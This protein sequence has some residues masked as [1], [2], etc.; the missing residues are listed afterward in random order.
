LFSRI[1]PLWERHATNRFLTGLD[2]L[3][4]NAK[5]IPRLSAL[6]HH[7]HPLTGFRARAVSGYIPSYFFF[8]RLRRREFPTTITIRDASQIDYL[9]EPDIFHDVAGHVPMHT[10]PAF[11][12][13]L[14]KFGDCAHSAMK[15]ASGASDRMDVLANILKGM[16]RF[17][18]FTVEFGLMNDGRGLKAYG[19][20]LMSSFGELEHSVISPEVERR[21]MNMEQVIHQPF[22]I[23]H[24]QPLLYVIES[25]EQLFEMV[26]QLDHW[27]QEGRL[28]HVAAGEPELAP[29]DLRSFVERLDLAA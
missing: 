25:F 18:W 12:N 27:I 11:A 21:P 7:L 10:D 2:L 28:N 17:F 15:S 24:Y 20:G 1:R 8:D 19:S 9:P 14:V 4:L 3:H 23:D 22:E 16:A 29:E 5:R 6:N 13:T 26:D